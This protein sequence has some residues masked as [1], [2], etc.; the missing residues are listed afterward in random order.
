MLYIP[1]CNEKM[2]EAV[3]IQVTTWMNIEDIK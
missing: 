2:N 1:N 3:M